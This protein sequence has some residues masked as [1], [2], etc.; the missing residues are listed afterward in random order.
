MTAD[1]DLLEQFLAL[2]TATVS[3]A[4]DVC[5]L[6][7]GQGGLPPMWGRPRMAGFAATVELGPLNAE[8]AGAHILTD[9]IAKAGAD[10]VMVVANGGRINVSCWGG[11]VSVGTAMRSIRGVVTDGAC[12]DVD[13]A[14]ELGFPVFARAQVPVTA[15]GRLQQKSAG[16]PV[17]LGQVTVN[18]GDVVMADEGGVVV[19]PRER[20]AEVLDAARGVRAREEQ[21]ENEV[22][23]GVPLPQAMRD[24]RLAGTESP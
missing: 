3:D 15:R 12:R 5:G 4:L 18:P 17:R 23:A 7:P 2:D 21:I 11:I 9:A 6:P 16:A 8:H 1:A 14:R 22:R 19:I 10:N 20:A 13:Q 24:A